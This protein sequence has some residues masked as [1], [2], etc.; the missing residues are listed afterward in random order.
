MMRPLIVANWKEN[1]TNEEVASFISAFRALV[2]G[3]KDRDIVLCPSYVSIITAFDCLK[4]SDMMVGSQDVSASMGGAFT[5]EVSASMLSDFC[6]YVIVGHSERRRMCGDRDIGNKVHCATKAGMIAILCVGE[7]KEERSKGM[8][9][10]V[11][12]RQL[13]QG[14]GAEPDLSRIVVA[15]EPVW[16]IS[17]GDKA[18][19]SATPTIAQDVHEFILS[20]MSKRFGDKAKSVRIIYGG[21]VKPENIHSFMEQKDVS[22]ALVGNASLDPNSFARIVLY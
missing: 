2:A 4:G 13:D 21:S 12:T 8:T 1:K 22:G 9:K 20:H 17:G 16:A 5:G 11:L 10:Q 14:L 18:H 6:R 15:Y 3:S 19:Q 7:S